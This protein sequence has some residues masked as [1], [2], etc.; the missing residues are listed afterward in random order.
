[1]IRA[2]FEIL[3]NETYFTNKITIITFDSKSNGLDIAKQIRN[4]N[5]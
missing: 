1:M 5:N 3:R 4:F 2:I